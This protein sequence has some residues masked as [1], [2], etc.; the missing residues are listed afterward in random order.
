MAAEQQ[1][2]ESPTPRQSRRCAPA[3][4]SHPDG[5]GPGREPIFRRREEPRDGDAVRGRARGLRRLLHIPAQRAARG[6]VSRR[7]RTLRPQRTARTK[8]RTPPFGPRLASPR[9]ILIVT[10][11]VVVASLIGG[12]LGVA[13][14]GAR[15]GG[16]L[17]LS[18]APATSK[19][20]SHTAEVLHAVLPGIVYLQVVADGQQ[21]TGTG[22]LLDADGHILTNSHVVAPDGTPGTVTVTFNTGQRHPATL[23]GRDVGTDLAVLRVT[24]VSGLTPAVLGDSDDIQVGDPVMAV[25]DPYGLRGTVTSGIVSALDRPIVS[26][27][28]MPGGPSYLDAVQTDAAIN[29]GNSGGPLLDAS[30]TVIGINTVIRSADPDSTDPYGNS[31]DSGSIG[32]GFAIPIDQA[33]AVAAQLIGTGHADPPM[34]GV[35]L[36]RSFQGGAKITAVAQRK[37]PLHVGDI[38]TADDG[39][40]VTDADDLIALVRGRKQNAETV[41]TVLRDGDSLPVVVHLTSGPSDSTS[42]RA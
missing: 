25:G 21:T 6:S 35:T 40:A 26:G 29:P 12:G 9:G 18:K 30:G 5:P 11:V 31:S 4:W 34:I 16:R 32:L 13:V 39:I 33:A 24:G 14:E 42:T 27:P 41:L 28:G 17:T 8:R 3:W 1:V 37:S 22:V 38:V 19:T 7:S 10:V 23:V 15:Q 36:D 20:P 2:E